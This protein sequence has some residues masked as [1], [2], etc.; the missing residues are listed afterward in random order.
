M[1]KEYFP[2]KS[3]ANLCNI[4]QFAADNVTSDMTVKHNTCRFD[5][6]CCEKLWIAVYNQSATDTYMPARHYKTISGPCHTSTKTAIR[7]T[8]ARF[9]VSASNNGLLYQTMV[10]CIMPVTASADPPPKVKCAHKYYRNRD[11]HK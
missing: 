8:R 5:N 6:K 10:Y 3:P 9:Y 7:L 2:Y 4:Y 1:R 11:R